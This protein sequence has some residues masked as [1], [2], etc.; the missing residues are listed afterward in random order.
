DDGS[1]IIPE[2][3]DAARSVDIEAE[4]SWLGPLSD[5]MKEALELQISTLNLSVRCHRAL[6]ERL[7]L[8]RVGDILLFSEEDLLGMP[9]FGITSLNELQNKLNEFGL[10]LRSGRGDEYSGD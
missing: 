4:L 7:N 3:F 8:Q 6:V 5:E 10:R 9:N 1:F 2:E